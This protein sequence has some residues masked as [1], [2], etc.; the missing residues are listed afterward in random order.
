MQSGKFNSQPMPNLDL[1]PGTTTRH[2][3][4]SISGCKCILL[5]IALL[6]L[7]AIGLFLF[8]LFERFIADISQPHRALFENV[9]LEDVTN[10]P[11]AV[12]LLISQDQTFD[13]AATVWMRTTERVGNGEVFAMEANRSQA[14]IVGRGRIRRADRPTSRHG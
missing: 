5:T 3:G 13:I 12:Q 8:N 14:A 6:V 9:A 4:K 11:T 10:H 7:L 1:D 2:P